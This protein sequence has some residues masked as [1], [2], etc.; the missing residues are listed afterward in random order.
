MEVDLTEPST[1]STTPMETVN[2]SVVNFDSEVKYS[3]KTMRDQFYSKITTNDAKKSW[4]ATCNIC[5]STIRGTAGVTS[6]Y[7]RHIKEFHKTQYDLWQQ[8]SQSESS[9]GQRKITEALKIQKNLHSSASKT[10]VFPSN[11]P[12]QIELEKSIVED[13]VIELGLPLSLIERAGFLKFMARVEPKF[14]VISRRSLTRS[15]LPSL[16]SKML[17]GLKSFCVTAKFISLTLDLWT[18][19]RQRAFFAVTGASERRE[20]LIIFVNSTDLFSV[21]G[22]AIVDSEFKSFLMSFDPVFGN[23]RAP[24]L[25]EMYET[26]INTFNIQTKLVRLITDSCSNNIAAFRGLIIPGFELYFLDDDSEDQV[27]SNSDEERSELDDIESEAAIIEFHNSLLQVFDSTSTNDESFRLP[28]YAHTLQ[29][30]IKDGLKGSASIRCSLEKVSKIAALSHSST[31]VSEHFEKIHVNIPKANKTRW[32]SQYETVLTVIGV[33]PTD[34]NDI[35]VKTQHRD[36]CL[37]PLDYQVLNEFV[38]LLALFADATTTTQAQ[39]TP[40]ISMVAPSILSIYQDLNFERG[41]VKHTSSLC[42]C[43]LESLSC[44]F[45]GLLEQMCIRVDVADKKKNKRFYDL[46]KD[47]VYLIAA[48]LDGRFRLQWTSSSLL[49]DQLQQELVDKIQQL[50]IQQCFLLEYA[51]KNPVNPMNDIR[52]ISPP[53]PSPQTQTSMNTASPGVPKRKSLFVNMDKKGVKKT[54]SDPFEPVK[55][56]ICRYLDDDNGDSMLLVKQA[57]QYPLL[58]KLALKILSIPATSAPVERVFSQ[59]GFLFRQHRASMTRATL[60][61]LTM[62]KC[63]RDLF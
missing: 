42:E 63:N 47:P 27:D 56:E 49:S 38:S 28:C 5:Q 11:H 9:H 45:G 39:N 20:T 37:K 36:L 12:R 33:Q 60:Q 22:H 32:N 10:A 29:L 44:R 8:Q 26:C 54:K 46:Y 52:I 62:L 2:A 24:L 18:D 50:V 53:P 23:H 43:L 4:E 1:A 58:S 16:Y 59:S 34:L 30:V 21:S 40:S 14:T 61:Q 35:L 55:K 48:F 6:N 13:L 17:E 41:N 3:S 7:N 25:L 57:A 19:R 15:A 51:D 31:L